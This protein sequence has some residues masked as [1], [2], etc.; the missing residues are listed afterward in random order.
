M[1]NIIYPFQIPI[2]QSYIDKDSF[3]Q[4]KSDT[5]SYIDK[6][7]EVFKEGWVSNTKTS[8]YEEKYIFKNFNLETCIKSHSQKFFKYW[9]FS[10]SLKFN[11][12][13]CWVNVA[14]KGS[15]Q[16]PHV[17]TSTL[18]KTNIFSGVLYIDTPINSGDIRFLNPL[19]TESYIM[20]QNQMFPTNIHIKPKNMMILIFPSW[21]EH[22]VLLNNSDKSRISISWNISCNLLN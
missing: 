10:S 18:P 9:G 13:R 3:T 12:S 14:K 8:F 5:L 21:L 6:N 4:I 11:L 19:T 15:Y 2:Y 1:D 17:H 22:S 20:P 7:W 16:D